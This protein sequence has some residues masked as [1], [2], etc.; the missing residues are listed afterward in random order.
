MGLICSSWVGIARCYKTPRYIST[1]P[2]SPPARHEKTKHRPNAASSAWS[3]GN[4][5]LKENTHQTLQVPSRVTD[6]QHERT[7][8]NQTL[9][10]HLG[11]RTLSTKGKH[12]SN[13]AS[14][15][16]SQEHSAPNVNTN[17]TDTQVN[18]RQDCRCNNT[19]CSDKEIRPMVGFKLDAFTPNAYQRLRYHGKAFVVL[20][21]GTC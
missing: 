10:F 14:S 17:Q 12:K 9:Q 20:T 1:T 13:G 18:P 11:S 4:S 8:T 6:P 16:L 2:N 5:A 7:N 15:I 19:T 21:L 3:H